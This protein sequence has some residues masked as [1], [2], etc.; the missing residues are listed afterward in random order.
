MF[1]LAFDIKDAELLEF[2]MKLRDLD[3]NKARP[4]Q[5]EIKYQDHTQSS[6]GRDNAKEV[7]FKKVDPDLLRKSSFLQLMAMMDNYN[8]QTGIAE[9]RTSVEESSTSSGHPFTTSASNFRQWIEHLWFAHYSRAKGKLDTSGFEHVFMGEEKNNEVSG[10]HNWVRFYYL[11]KNVT[12]N[13]DYKGF[14]VKRGKVMASLKFTWQKKLKRSGSILIGTSPEY[15]MALYT[16]CFLSRRGKELCK[17][18]YYLN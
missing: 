3:H 10:L 16:L 11:E 15:D 12:E 9:P 14:I 6:D 7:F 8:R 18:L 4:G 5:I 17:M 1:H 2:S 13:F